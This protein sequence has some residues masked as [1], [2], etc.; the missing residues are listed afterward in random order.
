M[1]ERLL[2]RD[3]SSGEVDMVLRLLESYFPTEGFLRDGE[4]SDSNLSQSPTSTEEFDGLIRQCMINYMQDC[5]GS[6]SVD[7]FLDFMRNVEPFA[8]QWTR[9]EDYIRNHATK[10]WRM[11]D[12]L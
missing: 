9:A 2:D 7:G 1:I 11:D 6:P 10:L 12:G 4:R 8:G 3:A 5:D